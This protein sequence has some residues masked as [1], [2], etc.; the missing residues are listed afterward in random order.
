[1]KHNVWAN[2]GRENR[3]EHKG[4]G[5]KKKRKWNHLLQVEK[6]LQG[7]TTDREGFQKKENGRVLGTDTHKELNEED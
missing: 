4:G 1:M 3:T 2:G 6:G 7:L 5:K